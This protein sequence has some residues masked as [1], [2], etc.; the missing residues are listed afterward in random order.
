MQGMETPETGFALWKLIATAIFVLL[1][2]YFVGAEFALVKVRPGKMEAR[3]SK[4]QG[5][6]KIVVKMLL[7][8]D[9]YLSACQLGITVASLILGWL[10]EPAVAALLIELASGAGMDIAANS[11]LHPVALVIS[12][13]VI[14]LLHMT[15]GEQA[16]KMY[17]IQRAETSILLMAY[18]LY[19]FASIF[20]PLIWIINWISNW[21]IRLVGGH[22]T[23]E[24]HE[25]YDLSEIRA[26]L[27]VAAQSGHL[28]HRQKMF[29]E[30][31]LGLTNLEVRHVMIP[32]MEVDFLSTK[33]EL[34]ANLEIVR[35]TG[36]SRYPLGS[37]DLDHVIGVIHGK[38]LLKQFIEGKQPDLKAAARKHLVVPDT[39][40]LSRLILDM[41]EKQTHCAQV[42]DEHG[43]TIGFVFLE[44]AI[45]EIVGPIYDE[46]DNRELGLKQE[47]EGVLLL[48]G[49]MPIPDASEIL[50]VELDDE[51]DTIG[52][53]VVA[54]L[55]RRPKKGEI[56]DIGSYTVTVMTLRRNRLV[57]LQFEKK[58]ID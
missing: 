24:H 2:G 7:Q 21:L 3:A 27:A 15:I 46:F 9:L 42:E 12:L 25:S 41:Q 19:F 22:S 28:S 29:S 31:I 52:G 35:K 32:R 6:A 11:W 57:R 13:L 40:R 33:K 49:S 39:E 16:P 45:E 55:G 18:P 36:H 37:T 17:S 20:K 1:N 47:K 38:T 5:S 51:T 48:P 14:T 44:D 53:L 43:T 50:G 58:L 30:N 56:L 26:I 23:N 34:K 10:A 54:R 8:L 4:G